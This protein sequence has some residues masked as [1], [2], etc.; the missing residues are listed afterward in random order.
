MQFLVS[1]FHLALKIDNHASQYEH[2]TEFL[3]KMHKNADSYQ[4]FRF[5]YQLKITNSILHWFIRRTY[6]HDLSRVTYKTN[7]FSFTGGRQ[8]CAV[9]F[10]FSFLRVNWKIL[11]TKG[12]VYSIDV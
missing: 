7:I 2:F 1:Q 9:F 5:Y 6:I 10:L 8:P 11:E 4:L 3:N 12:S